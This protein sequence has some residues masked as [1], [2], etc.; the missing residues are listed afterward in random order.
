MRSPAS[1]SIDGGLCQK[2]SSFG[3]RTK[4]K[5]YVTQQ[6]QR[7]SKHRLWLRVATKFVELRHERTQCLLERDQADSTK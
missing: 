4:R 7:G 3:R 1:Q 2:K 6:R 5:R